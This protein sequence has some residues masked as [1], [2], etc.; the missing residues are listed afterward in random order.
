MSSQNKIPLQGP[1]F[2][3]I[4]AQKAGTT[5]L[6]EA[7]KN[8]KQIWLPPV[9]EIHYFTN[10]VFKRRIRDASGHVV[11]KFIRHALGAEWKE[12]KWLI[13]YVFE[14][15]PD[16]QWYL[17][18]FKYKGNRLS[19]DFTP[20]YSKIDMDKI[21]HA[22]QLLPRTKIIFIMR[23][24]ID[25]VWSALKMMFGKKYLSMITNME[26]K[27]VIK[28]IQSN[29]VR[30][31]TD[32]VTIID[33]WSACYSDMHICFF[34]ELIAN[35]E[36]FMKE[37]SDYIGIDWDKNSSGCINTESVNKGKEINIPDRLHNIIV[38]SYADVIK[39][40]AKRYGS[41]ALNW[42]NQL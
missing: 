26:D 17:D 19:G 7:L 13:D 3:V 4:G 29:P 32:Y 18:L 30:K 23:N 2:L 12:C 38:D 11:N 33:N 24:P 21:R 42:Q 10:P 1:D 35:P 14:T 40:I 41:Y 27:E 22:K 5:W 37:I 36:K 15:K 31:R 25:R 20:D 39:E 28:I 8:H 34:D 9:K 16:D 6:Y